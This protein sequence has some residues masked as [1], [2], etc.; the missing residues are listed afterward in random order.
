[1][2]RNTV[3]GSRVPDAGLQDNRPLPVKKRIATVDSANAVPCQA[4]EQVN[5]PVSIPAKPVRKP[6]NTESLVLYFDYPIGKDDIHPDLKNNR[7]EIDKV[8]R[9]FAPLQREHFVSVRSVRICGYCSPDGNY[10]D[11]ERL[12]EARSRFFSIYLCGVYGH[13]SRTG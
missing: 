1:M 6:V 10:G 4:Q 8:D 2:I 3:P 5:V 11:N 9:L 12:A 7:Y 13:S